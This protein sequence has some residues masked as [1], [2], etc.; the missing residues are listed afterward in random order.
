MYGANVHR[1]VVILPHPPAIFQSEPLLSGVLVHT[2][3]PPILPAS[4][5]HCQ[6][7]HP[8]V[9]CPCVVYFAL[10]QFAAEYL[11]E[12]NSELTYIQVKAEVQVVAGMM[13]TLH[14]RGNDAA[15]DCLEERTLVV[16]D[17]PW[18]DERTLKSDTVTECT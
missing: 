12:Q 8:R 18:L 17:K 6:L 3:P 7:R 16:Y 4:S 11:T 9:S 14:Y 1:H 5:H 10:W 2:S 13:Y 15:G